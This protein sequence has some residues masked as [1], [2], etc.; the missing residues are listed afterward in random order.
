[1]GPPAHFQPIQSE[2][3][4]P[5]GNAGLAAHPAVGIYDQ[6][7]AGNWR[8]ELQQMMHNDDV[9]EMPGYQA[10]PEGWQELGDLDAMLAENDE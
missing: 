9:G 3:L 4:A 7:G 2:N 5:H 8:P 10:L 1:M 6:A